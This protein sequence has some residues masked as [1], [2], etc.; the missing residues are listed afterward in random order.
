LLAARLLDSAGTDIRRIRAAEL[1]ATLSVGRR[2]L[3]PRE[4]RDGW[5]RSGLAHVLAVSGLHVGLVGGM[6]WLILVVLGATPRT[7]R[8]AVLIVLP[9]YALLAGASPSAVRAAIMGMVYLGARLAGRALVPMAAVLLTAFVLLLADPSLVAEISFQ[10]TV[11]LTAALVRWGPPLAAAI[12]APRWLAAVIAVPVV[13]QLAAAP[14]VAHHFQAAVPGAVL[15]NLVVPLLLGPV[16]VASVAAT[17]LAPVWPT[18]AGWLVEIVGAG[19]TL[20]WY[21]GAPGR[22]LE[23]VPPPLPFPLLVVLVAAGLAALLPGRPGRTGA[24]AYLTAITLSAVWW[25]VL[26]PP[27]GTE[28]ELLP[29]SHGLAMRIGTQDHQVLLDGGGRRREAA[30]LLAGSRVRRLAAVIASHSDE[31]HIAG[32]ELV[33]RTFSTD[34]LILPKWMLQSRESLGM[35][36]IARRRDVEIVPVARGSTVDIGPASMEVLWPP[37]VDPPE[38]ENERSLVAMLRLNGGTTLLTSDIGRSTELRLL[39][40]GVLSSEILLAPHHGSRHSSS[41]PF[42]DAVRPRLALIPA[43]P[44]NLHNHPHPEV[45][46]RFDGR[47]ID[48]RMPIRD[49]RCGARWIDGEWKLYP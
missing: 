4:R 44:E 24:T 15:A 2:D 27:S 26:P 20:L 39:E 41:P 11:L 30:V 8:L 37:A 3:V 31:D 38:I 23:L 18:A 29:V 10:L 21:C 42:L 25:L 47:G 33:L 36:R 16:V 12:P 7:T 40:M 46:D 43:G 34:R 1:A 13:A 32:I 9:A 49:G 5:R 17:A 35:I 14:L 19:G 48:Y 28:I 45:L 22:A 6:T